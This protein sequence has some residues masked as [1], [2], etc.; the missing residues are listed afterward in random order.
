MLVCL[1]MCAWLVFTGTSGQRRSR[2]SKPVE[3]EE[4]HRAKGFNA[5]EDVGVAGAVWPQ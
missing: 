3:R 2:L 4:I 5:R 1:D